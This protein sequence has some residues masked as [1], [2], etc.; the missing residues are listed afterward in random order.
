MVGFKA[1][2]IYST[3]LMAAK[4]GIRHHLVG[5]HWMHGLRVAL[6]GVTNGSETPV[7]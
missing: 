3:F 4:T 6:S 5:K 1:S 2:L 7:A